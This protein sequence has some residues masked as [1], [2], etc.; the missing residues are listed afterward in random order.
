MHQAKLSKNLEKEH[1]TARINTFLHS[2]YSGTIL[3]MI[4]ILV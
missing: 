3:V 2:I 4:A 1:P